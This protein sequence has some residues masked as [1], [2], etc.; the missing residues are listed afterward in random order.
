MLC[1]DL[2]TCCLLVVVAFCCISCVAW[3]WLMVVCLFFWG[4]VRCSL[5]AVYFCLFD[6]CCVLTDVRCSLFVGGCVLFVVCC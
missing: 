2:R 5:F 3:C 1:V 4:I 6:V